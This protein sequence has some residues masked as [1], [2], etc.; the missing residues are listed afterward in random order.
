MT[1]GIRAP[2]EDDREQ[3]IDPQF[4]ENAGPW[5]LVVRGGEATVEAA[6]GA[7]VRPL[8]IGIISSMFTGFLRVPDA[9]R[10]GYLD[11]DDPAVPALQRL[12]AGADPWCPFFF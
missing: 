10:M 12:L 9:V 2:V 5:R 8:P 1:T 6:P 7:D 11:R 4:P 3:I